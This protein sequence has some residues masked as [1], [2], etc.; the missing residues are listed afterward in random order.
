MSFGPH[1]G[2]G[3]RTPKEVYEGL[4]PANRKARWE[5]RPKWPPDSPCA[6]PQARP[7]RRQPRRLAIVL[8]LHEGSRLLPIVELKR[9]A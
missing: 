9:V 8:R 1:Q 7:K 5:P 3:G 6:Q 2:L 4:L